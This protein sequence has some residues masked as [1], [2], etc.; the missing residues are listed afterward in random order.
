MIFQRSN[1]HWSLVE[2]QIAAQTAEQHLCLAGLLLAKCNGATK[3]IR[4]CL[5]VKLFINVSF[6]NKHEDVSWFYTKTSGFTKKIMEFTSNTTDFTNIFSQFFHRQKVDFHRQKS[7]F[8]RPTIVN[9]TNS[10]QFF[11]EHVW[12]VVDLPLWKIWVGM[13]TFSIYGQ[14]KK[15]PNNQPDVDP[16]TTS[17]HEKF[18]KKRGCD[19]RKL[20]IISPAGMRIERPGMRFLFHIRHLCYRQKLEF[21]QHKYMD[22]PR[23][24]H[25]QLAM[26]SLTRL[27]VHAQTWNFGICK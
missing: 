5:H 23:I 10:V 24:S 9:I 15:V 18:T 6:T 14:I 7:W 8:H 13:M 11:P 2:V 16:P 20:S 19:Q 4:G 27:E 3:N 21:D 17:P 12:L 25:Q 22:L 1:P 26:I